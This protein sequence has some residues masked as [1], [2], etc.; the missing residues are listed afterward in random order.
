MAAD[1]LAAFSAPTR[2]WFAAAF[3]APTPP[4][5]RGWPAIA[6]GDHTLIVAPTGTGK[7]LAAFLWA[8]DRLAATDADTGAPGEADRIAAPAAQPAETAPEL[9]T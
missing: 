4:Q 6:S 5:A 3:A 7:T 2:A 1:P 8:L 9:D